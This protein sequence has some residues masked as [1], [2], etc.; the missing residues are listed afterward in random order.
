MELINLTQLTIK[1]AT[2]DKKQKYIEIKPSGKIAMPTIIPGL[3]IEQQINGYKF[4]LYTPIYDRAILVS[5]DGTKQEPFPKMQDD[6]YYI[7]PLNIKIEKEL[8]YRSDVLTFWDY[9]I[10]SDTITATSTITCF[11]LYA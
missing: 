5:I 4:Q 7:V 9:E 11:S 10:D 8:R 3:P 2:K 1:I 6:I